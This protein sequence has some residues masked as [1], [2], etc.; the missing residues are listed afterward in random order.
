[1]P[2]SVCAAIGQTKMSNKKD[3]TIIKDSSIKSLPTQPAISVIAEPQL[4]E[5]T[6]RVLSASA[7]TEKDRN[8]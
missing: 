1:M 2:N 7:S 6:E 8:I 5:V 4:S 3:S